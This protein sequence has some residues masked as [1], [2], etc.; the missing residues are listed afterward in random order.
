MKPVKH[1]VLL[2]LSYKVRAQ[3]RDKASSSVI[4]LVDVETDDV[5]W[6]KVVNRSGI[7]IDH[8]I[9]D[10]ALE[11]ITAEKSIRFGIVI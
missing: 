9:E 10:R 6:D 11:G 7:L 4:H 2:W 3:S 1:K 8:E 5:V